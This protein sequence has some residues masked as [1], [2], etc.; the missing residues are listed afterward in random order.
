MDQ[1]KLT[2]AIEF[3]KK[4]QLKKAI[5]IYV[6]LLNASEFNKN[7]ILFL[8]GTACYQSKNFK[9]SINYFKNLLSIDPNN[10]HAYS[11][12]ALAQ[13]ELNRI[14]E[15]ISS[16][17]KSIKI[18]PNFSHSF[19]NLGNLFLSIDDYK[20][21]LLNFNNALQIE[22]L[23]DFF[24]NR[25]RVH[26][27]LKNHNQAL[28]D[29]EKYLHAFPESS[30][31]IIFK[32]EQLI[33]TNKLNTCNE[34]LKL[35][36]KY[37][38]D[39]EKL[40]EL[41]VKY[42]LASEK[43]DDAKENIIHLKNDVTKNFYYSIYFYKKNDL[44]TAIDKLNLL[45]ESEHNSNILNNFG[46]FYRE[47]G[48]DIKSHQFF[49]KALYLNPNNNFAKLNIGLLE[50]KQYNFADGWSNYFFR[51]KT[52]PKLSEIMQE[53]N[54]DYI[55]K[56]EILILNEQGIGDQILFLSILSF[57][58][59]QNFIFVVDERL[60]DIYKLNFP[61]IKFVLVKDLTALNCKF[62]IYLADLLKYFIKERADLIK[63][64]PSFQKI[65]KK[66]SISK[67]PNSFNIGFSWKSEKSKSESKSR[68]IDI[69]SFIEPLIDDS[70]VFHSL[71]YGNIEE[72]LNMVKDKFK[73]KVIS[74]N[75]NYFN[76]L[77]ILISIINQLD[78]VVTTDNIT[79]HL[80]GAAGKKTFVLV[81]ESSSRIWFWH[82]ETNHEWYKNT[83]IYFFNSSNIKDIL[84]KIKNKIINSN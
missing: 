31:A 32:I 79:A 58:T 37:I 1:S 77:E 26:D 14:D 10:F 11:N 15:A 70:F 50:L 55:P 59:N 38:S 47:L 46:L 82:N 24:F 63:I 17:N 27:K 48:D 6:D 51:E 13:K 42:F 40:N 22:Q 65:T 21:A 30:K 44:Q 2:K 60:I 16:F 66:I 76:D 35:S 80:A 84:G 71:Q 54:A 12:M 83:A 9:E 23:P 74:Q 67:K 49:T 25:A 53:W 18:N 34:Y 19:N 33:Y 7:Q 4:N 20:N 39:N 57:I 69:S 62:Y 56:H 64:T 73:L 81:P 8:L 29:I 36:S 72:D 41:Y 68:S 28:K 61:N 45:P 3:H 5:K 43:L 52:S 78:Y 75:I